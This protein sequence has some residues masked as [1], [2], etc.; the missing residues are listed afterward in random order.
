MCNLDGGWQG[1]CIP[2]IPEI[3]TSVWLSPFTFAGFKTPGHYTSSCGSHSYNPTIAMSNYLQEKFQRWA[4]RMEI[5][6]TLQKRKA[7]EAS[8]VQLRQELLMEVKDY[9]AYEELDLFQL[10][11]PPDIARD[12]SLVARAEACSC[13]RQRDEERLIQGLSQLSFNEDIQNKL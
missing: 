8:L 3:P 7:D 4:D 6:F 10:H 13:S 1:R 5:I 2:N 12:I 11:I 9:I